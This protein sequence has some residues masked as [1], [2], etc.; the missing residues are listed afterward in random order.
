MMKRGI[1]DLESFLNRHEK[2]VITTHES[3]DPDGLGAEVAFYN[4]LCHLGKK[5]IIV[6]AD[7]TPEKNRFIDYDEKIQLF[8]A[9]YVIPDDISEYGIIIL[10]TNDYSNTGTVY[11][12]FKHQIADVFIIDHH[13]KNDDDVGFNL[14]NPKAS[15][16]GEIV[17]QILE[18]FK[19]PVPFKSALGIYA[20]ILFDTGSFRYPKTSSETFRVA[21]RLVDLGISPNWVYEV[22]YETYSVSSLMLKS[23]M[24]S[25]MEFLFDGRLVLMH[26]TQEMLRE[27][28]GVFSEGEININI[29]LT[30]KDVIASVLI[31]QDIDGPIKVS[32]RTKGDL[33]VADIA[34]S[35][36][37]GGHKNAAG[38][39][40]HLSW[41]ETRDQLLNDMSVFFSK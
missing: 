1:Q 32:M 40:S 14:I 41:N 12:A 24:L 38:Y 26:L 34:I 29:P 30:V 31:K 21:S 5:P 35:R 9:K 28:G 18:H 20:G 25:S 39:K 15:S 16:T 22:M 36:K 17:Y 10:D 27:T 19:A 33:N 37:G 23:K 2:F 7:K 4:F 8:D 3:P 11:Y 6:N 13:T